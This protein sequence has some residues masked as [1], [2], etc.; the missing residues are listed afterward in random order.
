MRARGAMPEVLERIRGLIA[1]EGLVPGMKLPAE[2]QMAARLRVGRPAVRE[3]I[4]ALSMLGL[5]E[6]R[7]RD[8]TY[9]RSAGIEYRRLPGRGEPES[10]YDLIE[11][12]EVRR[13]IEPRAASLAASRAGEREL[14][15]IEAELLAQEAAPEDFR[16]LERHD[17][18]FH[19]AIVRAAGN[20]VVCDIHRTLAAPLRKSRELTAHTTP[21][22][23]RIVGQHRA[24][25]DSI[26]TRQPELAEK[27]MMN[28]LVTV[29]LDLISERR[30]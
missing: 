25:F 26:R 15:A 3:A 22:V 9:V 5:V 13:M 17:Y 14:R 19:E 6:S 24:I 18:R 4:K 23:P 20:R 1:E 28:H 27:A 7:W 29:A 16:V 21:D 2:R 8:G 11:L 30:R 10:P 12:L